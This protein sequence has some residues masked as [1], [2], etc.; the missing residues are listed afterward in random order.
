[1][2][3]TRRRRYI[4]ASGLALASALGVVQAIP[5]GT[6]AFRYGSAM[7]AAALPVF[8]AYWRHAPTTLKAVPTP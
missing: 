5:P 8:F 7:L 2:N 1:M 4:E 6:S 3:L